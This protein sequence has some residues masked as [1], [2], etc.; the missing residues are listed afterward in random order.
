MAKRLSPHFL[1]LVYDA[2][3]KSFWRKKALRQFL[4]RSR[5]SESFVA[6]LDPEDSKRDYLDQLFPKLEPSERGQALIQ[7]IARSL[8]DQTTFPDLQGWEDSEDKIRDAK[9]AVKALR[10]FLDERDREKIDER[11]A[12]ERRKEAETARLANVRS[13]ADL[14]KLKERLDA[15]CSKLGTQ[16]GGYA[17]Q[18]WFYDLMEYSEIDSRR[19]YIAPGGRQIDGSI[20]I[21]GTT[22]LVEIKFTTAPAVPTDIDSFDKKVE[23]KADNTMGIMVSMSSYNDGAK[24]EASYDKSPLLLLDYSHLYAV[25]SGLAT[26]ADVVRRVRRHS[27]QEGRAYLAFNDF[28]G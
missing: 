3:L 12:V 4:R 19:P 26:F 13:Q 1:D 22:Y 10:D 6:G 25:L 21:D 8:A 24:D 28:G 17:F 2:A 5:V 16:E 27:S 11:Q 18:D 23:R 14:T 9:A 7:Q 20:T 15:L